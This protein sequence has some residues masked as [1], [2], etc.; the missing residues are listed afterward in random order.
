MT[1]EAAN[2]INIKKKAARKSLRGKNV[3][4]QHLCLC[5]LYLL[6]LCLLKLLDELPQ[7]AAFKAL[8]VSRRSSNRDHVIRLIWRGRGE[9]HWS[10]AC[11]S[12][13]KSNS[14]R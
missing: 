10:E 3:Q 13:L 5:F 7:A 12:K 14:E 11:L 9:R 8:A 2:V 6:F 1:N 4:L